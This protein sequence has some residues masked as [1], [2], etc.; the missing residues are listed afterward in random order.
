MNNKENFALGIDI[1]GTKIS[2]CLI[3]KKGEII[4]EIKKEHTPKTKDEIVSAFKNIISKYEDSDID[5]V[6]IAT[7][8]AVNKEHNKIVGST[9]NLP[10]GYP[11]IAFSKLSSKKTIFIENDANCASWAEHKIGASKDYDNSIMLT[12]GTGVGGGIIIE[13]KLL[14]GASGAAGE[15]HF[16]MSREFKRA[17]TCGNHDCFE[18]YASGNGL[19]KTASEIFQDDTITTYDV[20]ARQKEGDKKAILALETWQ[21]DIKDGILSLQNIFDTQCFVLSGSMAKFIDEKKIES[22]V[23]KTSLTSSIKVKQ[24]QTGDSSGMIGAVLL[25]YDTLKI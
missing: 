11:D 15:V 3:N 9:G 2:Y 4:G 14:K 10:K 17:C 8:G 16:I 25:A 1:G 18:A 19:R 22:E 23:N 21:N 12:F 24:A 20:I 13:N 7:A 5:F 6:A